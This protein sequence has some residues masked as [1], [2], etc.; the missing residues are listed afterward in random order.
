ME[1][2]ALNDVIR[3]I[4][5]RVESFGR[6][7]DEIAL[8]SHIL[9][10]NTMI[11]AARAGRHGQGFTVVA[12]EMKR[13]SDQTKE[14]S[15]QF[16]V[17]VMASV[18]SA[19]DSTQQ[20][21][22]SLDRADQDRLQEKA[23]GLVQLIVRNLFE[24]TADVRWWATDSAFYSALHN[25]S[26]DAMAHAGERLQT[27]HRYYTVYHDLMLLDLNG[28]V[29][30]S[31]QG[32]A[33]PSPRPLP[34][35]D[36]DWFQRAAHLPSGHDY[37]VDWVRPSPL[38][39]GRHT[40]VYAAT[41][42]CGGAHDGTPVGVLAIHFNWQDEAQIIVRDEA[43]FTP[44]EWKTHRVLLLDG[45]RRIIASSDGRD[46]LDTFPLQ[47]QGAA[48][49]CYRMPAGQTVGFARTIGYQDYDGL[50]WYGVVIAG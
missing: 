44:D 48:R 3:R 11:E 26:A 37:V 5:R 4:G 40:L 22:N 28:R 21:M 46:L 15:E 38:H 23:L 25:K 7:S 1:Q 42:R 45:Q 32:G 34:N 27:I 29:V 36:R 13:L 41:V 50:G 33:Y 8:Q 16:R 47:D 19:Q 2:G 39:D 43:G 35:E 10:V 24:R 31:A 14:H 6:L 18:Q 17:D 30:A 20:L 12:A 9:A 49:G